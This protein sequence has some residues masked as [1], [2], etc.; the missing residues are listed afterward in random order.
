MVE[1]QQ[2]MGLTVV[3]EKEHGAYGRDRVERQRNNVSQES[4]LGETIQWL[5]ERLAKN[6][7]T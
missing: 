1:R 3:Q 6:L 5:H 7:E 4:I 2:E